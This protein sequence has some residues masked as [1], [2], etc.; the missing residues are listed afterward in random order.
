MSFK[1]LHRVLEIL[2]LSFLLNLAHWLVLLLSRGLGEGARCFFFLHLF[3]QSCFDFRCM[4]HDEVID[5]PQGRRRDYIDIQFQGTV[6][7]DLLH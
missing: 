3:P 5:L 4:P 2:N 1:F 7:T 6:V